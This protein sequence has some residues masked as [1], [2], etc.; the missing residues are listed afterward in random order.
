M[1][2]NVTLNGQTF[3]IPA[4]GDDGWGTPLSSY[5]IAIST[6]V[7]QKTGGTFT[8]TGEADFGAGYG[9]KALYFKSRATNPS[10]AGQV[11]LGNTEAVS[12]RNAANTADLPLSVNASNQLEF[13]GSIVPS[14]GG[15]V[16]VVGS[17][18]SPSLIVAGDGIPFSGSYFLNT[19]YIAGS[20]GAVDVSANPQIPAGSTVGQ[21]LR[22]IA[23]SDVNTVTL[24]DGT[25]LDLNGM[26][27]GDANSALELDWT[28]SVWK[29]ISRR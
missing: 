11:R 17:Q 25:G 7:L 9:L 23:T 12:W 19:I 21:R 24:E 22:V 26:W 5:F 16:S 14:V 3:S 20:A 10:G 15:L 18:A 1:A 2:T 8:L 4:E 6:A 13:A 29:E 27:V 28:G